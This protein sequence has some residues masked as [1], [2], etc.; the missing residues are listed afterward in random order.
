V[1]RLSVLVAGLLDRPVSD[2]G[3]GAFASCAGALGVFI[4]FGCAAHDESR[5]FG[6]WL[7]IGAFF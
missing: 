3:S 6:V 7:K 2:S 4:R 1:G 5:E